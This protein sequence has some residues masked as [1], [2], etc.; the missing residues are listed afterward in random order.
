VGNWY[1]VVATYVGAMTL[2][3][4]IAAVIWTDVVQSAVLMVVPAIAFT[5]SGGS[6]LE[7]LSKVDSFFVCA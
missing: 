2:L 4:G 5:K 3:G 6:V 7:L 1:S